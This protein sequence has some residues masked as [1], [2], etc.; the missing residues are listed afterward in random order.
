MRWVMY[1]VLVVHVVILLVCVVAVVKR[2]YFDRR[3]DVAK[4]RRYVALLCDMLLRPD[5]DVPFLTFVGRE[6]SPE[7]LGYV[8]EAFRRQVA[9]YSPRQVKEM[10]V[11]AAVEEFFVGRMVRNHGYRD[12]P[13]MTVL[14]SIPLS[15]EGMEE[16][17]GHGCDNLFSD[18]LVTVIRLGTEPQRVCE[19]LS[20]HEKMDAHMA[21]RLAVRMAH[22][23]VRVDWERCLARADINLKL[24]GLSL[25]GTYHIVEAEE[26]IY[27]L[28]LHESQEVSEAALKCVVQLNLSLDHDNIVTHISWLGDDERRSVYRML[29]QG[30]YSRKALRRF[31]EH[32]ARVGSGLDGQ[33]RREF[34]AR[35]RSLVGEKV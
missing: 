11:A 33:I 13:A 31:A 28:L 1:A 23:R 2:L 27:E 6:D 5:D 8:M 32:E 25:V 3:H 35:R 10:V 24:V 12:V 7:C 21:A 4:E 29:V 22:D 20:E 14:S 30:G 19:V 17:A 9:E 26:R 34:G 15:A 16:V 18:Y